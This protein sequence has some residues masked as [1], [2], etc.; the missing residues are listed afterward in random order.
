MSYSDTIKVVHPAA[1]GVQKGCFKL[2]Y[3]P[4]HGS[5]QHTQNA[6]NWTTWHNMDPINTA[7][8]LQSELPDTTWIQS[9]HPGRFKLNYLTQHGSNQ[10]T[11]VASNWTDWHNMDPINTP[12][13]LQTE[14][15]DTTWIQSTHPG[16]FKLN[17]LTQHG[18]NQHTEVAPNWTTWHN[19]DPINTPRTLQTELPN[20]TWIQSTHP[21]RSK[22]NYLTQ[23]GSNQHSQVTSIWTTWHNMDPINTPRSLQTELPD[24]TWIKSTHPG[25][26]KLNYLTQHGSNQHTQVTSNWTT[27]HNMD[28]INTPRSL[29]TELPDTTWIQ[30]THPGRFKLNYRSQHG[31]NQHSQVASN[32]TTGHN[33]DPI[34]TPRSLQTELDLPD[35][36]WIQSTH[37]G[38]FKLNYLT[39]H[40]SNQHTQVTSN[41]TTCHNMD[42]IN[43]PRSLQT[44]LDLPDTTWIQSTHPG[45]FKLN[46]L[47]Q[48]GS[49]QHTQVA[50]NWTTCHNMDP[51]N[52]PRS[53]QT[54]LPDTTWIKSTQPG[55]FKLNYLTQHGSNQHTQVTSNWTRSTWH[56][57]D[58]INTPRS[59][60]TELPDTTWIQSTHPGH[61]KL[62]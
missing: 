55:R 53:L 32:W 50:S 28:Q 21:E 11:Q 13:S 57:M 52:T 20:T 62:N 44:E 2:N 10:H 47:T 40:G 14:L 51:I 23:H 9:T 15:I 29:Q 17:Y 4:Q 30:S 54:E 8:S 33:M 6:P 25:H 48:H 41:W 35:T 1:Q 45:H 12:R 26:F 19:M 43:T 3:Q 58:P 39:Q 16:H 27:W 49:N 37:P 22:L 36:T 56:N 46:Y 24:T 34:N 38:H 59:L 7:R 18:S 31:S 61:F 42:P 60:Q 5:N